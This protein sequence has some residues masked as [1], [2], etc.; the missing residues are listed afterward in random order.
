MH[1]RVALAEHLLLRDHL[2]GF[3]PTAETCERVD[4]L[5][6]PLRGADGLL[7]PAL[8]LEERIEEL[9]EALAGDRKKKGKYDAEAKNIE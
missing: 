3:G 7:L 4:A 5:L 2:T 8:G 6:R 9:V 1:P